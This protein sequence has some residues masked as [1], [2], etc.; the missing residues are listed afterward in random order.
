[1][2]DGPQNIIFENQF[3][4]FIDMSQLNNDA[5]RKSIKV[6]SAHAPIACI[7][8]NL[9]MFSFYY[10]PTHLAFRFRLVFFYGF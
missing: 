1:M 4:S 5:N 9:F 7:G 8:V 10:F 6:V 3:H 2:D